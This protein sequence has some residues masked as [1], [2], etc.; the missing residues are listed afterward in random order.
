M[1]RTIWLASYP[2]SGN[3]WFRMLI[4][5]L[6]RSEPADINALPSRGG[7]ASGRAMFDSAMLFPSALLTHDEC[8]R[9]RPMV[10]RSGAMHAWRDPDEEDAGEGIGG[11]HFIKTHD[12]WT[13][14]DDGVPL[15]GGAAAAAGAI[16]IVRDP[17]AVA[18][19]LAHHEARSI[20]DTIGFMGSR[21]SAFC[22]RDDRLHRQ[23]RQRLL[24][25]SAFHASWLDQA[26]L[27][28][29]CVRYED[30]HADPAARLAAALDF[31]GVAADRDTIARAVEF[32]RFDALTAQEREKG[33]REAPPSRVD[34]A[35]FRRG[36]AD[37]WRDELSTGQR[38]AIERDHH[39]MMQR[40]G[41]HADPPPA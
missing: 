33:F 16:L 21:T 9:M 8:D 39:A 7:I 13:I 6:G 38:R 40:L 41:Y 15:L 29:H 5:N 32:A 26:E 37:G 11:V 14:G 25:W 17:R 31:A 1:K 10:Y 30:M 12:G 24:G 23:L 19:S 36:R 2:K 3:T 28:V 22:G 27:P 34:R 20:D 18:A 4:A 35:F